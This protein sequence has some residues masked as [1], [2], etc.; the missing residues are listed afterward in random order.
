M[1]AP[2]TKRLRA[3]GLALFAVFLIAGGLV[4]SGFLGLLFA[5]VVALVVVTFMCWVVFV[6]D[7]H[8]HREDDAAWTLAAMSTLAI[9]DGIPQVGRI[10]IGSDRVEWSSDKPGVPPLLDFVREQ[11]VSIEVSGKPPWP[12]TSVLEIR[13]ADG[14]IQFVVQVRPPT[15]RA[16]LV[17]TGWMTDPTSKRRR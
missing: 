8:A 2:T 10:K 6:R 5:W 4:R 3:Y 13:E 17:R 11:V 15:L 16:A 9:A 1:R 14:P 7:R 12:M